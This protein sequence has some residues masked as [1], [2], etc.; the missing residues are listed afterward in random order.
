LD[1]DLTILLFSY[2]PLSSVVFSSAMLPSNIMAAFDD[3]VKGFDRYIM[4]VLWNSRLDWR[5]DAT[6][7]Y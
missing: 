6:W 4:I 3:G 2:Q 7:S 5:L 1:D